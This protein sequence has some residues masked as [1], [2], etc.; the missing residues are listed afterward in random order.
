VVL[1]DGPDL[2]ERV[3]IET[4]QASIKLALDAVAGEAT[5]RLGASL[6]DGGT[7]VKYAMLSQQPLQ[8]PPSELL[9]R[10][11]RL[12]G[13]F[14]GR[15]FATAASAISDTPRPNIGSA[16]DAALGCTSVW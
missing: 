12:R 15:W 10:D 8:I 3:S 4:G 11:L 6:A 16:P 9:F 14:L 5:T 7:L 1:V 13:F 2:A